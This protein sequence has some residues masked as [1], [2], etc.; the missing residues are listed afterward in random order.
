MNHFVCIEPLNTSSLDIKDNSIVVH[1]LQIQ[2]VGHL[3]SVE[4]S[5]KQG[6]FEICT[7]TRRA[8]APIV[9]QSSTGWV[10]SDSLAKIFN[11]RFEKV[12]D[13][14]DS[15]YDSGANGRMSQTIY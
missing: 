5:P 7:R 14:S 13:Y 4:A 15:H 2:T 12:A 11:R 8:P 6:S 10:A 3:G 9:S 1:S